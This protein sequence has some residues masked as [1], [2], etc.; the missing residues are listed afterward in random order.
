MMRFGDF[1][2]FGWVIVANEASDVAYLK[3]TPLDSI[4]L[5]L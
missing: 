3:F 1:M 2:K 5:P 4:I